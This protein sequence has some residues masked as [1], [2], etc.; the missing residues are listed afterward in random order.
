M[1][2]VHTGWAG[3]SYYPSITIDDNDHIYFFDGYAN[4]VTVVNGPYTTASA[5]AATIVFAHVSN[6][7]TIFVGG[8]KLFYTRTNSPANNAL[9]NY[10]PTYGQTQLA[11]NGVP[12][13]AV[14]GFAMDGQRNLYVATGATHVYKLVNGGLGG[15]ST[16]PSPSAM[17]VNPTS[18]TF[19]QAIKLFSAPNGLLYVAD[20]GINYVYAWNINGDNS[21]QLITAETATGNEFSY[22]SDVFVDGTRNLYVVSRKRKT[23]YTGNQASNQATRSTVCMHM[24][25]TYTKRT[26]IMCNYMYDIEVCC[27][28]TDD[29]D[30]DAMCVSLFMYEFLP[31]V[32]MMTIYFCHCFFIFHCVFLCLVFSFSFSFFLLLSG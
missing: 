3:G 8:G 30:D 24:K 14:S 17:V 12:A 5:A 1:L 21:A 20:V 6:I 18:L 22:P 9:P 2:C 26:Y 19:T 13:A 7:K 15:G 23:E 27:R 31:S 4:T 29:D 25:R 16:G 10:G 32:M 11:L 28:L